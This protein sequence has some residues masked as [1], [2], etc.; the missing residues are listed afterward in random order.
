MRGV[1]SSFPSQSV[2]ERTSVL[3]FDC[4]T[5]GLNASSRIVEIGLAM[6]DS[7]GKLL[8]TWST[9]LCGDR[10]I[11]EDASSVNGISNEMLR[12]APKFKSIAAPLALLM[13][14]TAVV[15]HN[16]KFDHRHLTYE[17][18]RLRE[19]PPKDFVCTM[20]LLSQF[21]Y[22]KLSLQRAAK[23]FKVNIDPDHTAET[24]AL[25]TAKLLQRLA[26]RHASEW[27]LW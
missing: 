1:A 20:S 8:G 14:S 11:D 3:V 10:W 27:T 24:D 6:V 21:G 19:K 9:L 23:V 15:A 2:L 25:V 22:G 18:S 5:T 26:H 16:A 7:S 17:Y 12:G 4:E 13:G